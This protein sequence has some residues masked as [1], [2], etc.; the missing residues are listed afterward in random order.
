MKKL[1][2]LL[3]LFLTGCVGLPEQVRPV[4]NF[5]QQSYLG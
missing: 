4:D 2:L 5:N 1:A 3:A